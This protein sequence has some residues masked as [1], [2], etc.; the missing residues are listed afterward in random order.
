MARYSKTAVP[1]AA[2]WTTPS[3]PIERKRGELTLED[4]DLSGAS[5]AERARA[6]ELVRAFD[7]VKG[8]MR[9][10]WRETLAAFVHDGAWRRLATSPS[11]LESYKKLKGNA[12]RQKQLYYPFWFEGVDFS[13]DR[14]FYPKVGVKKEKT[15]FQGTIEKPAQPTLED[16]NPTRQFTSINT[17]PKAIIPRPPGA[18]RPAKTMIATLPQTDDAV[19][20]Q[21]CLPSGVDLEDEANAVTDSEHNSIFGPPSLQE[22]FARIAASRNVSAIY[23]NVEHLSPLKRAVSFNLPDGSRQSSPGRDHTLTPRPPSPVQPAGRTQLQSSPITVEDDLVPAL[24]RQRLDA[25]T[26]RQME[27]VKLRLN[28]IEAQRDIDLENFQRRLGTT[29]TTTGRFQDCFN[30]LSKNA[31]GVAERLAKTEQ[32]IDEDDR[33]LDV[34]ELQH[35]QFEERLTQVDERHTQI[36]MMA[37]LAQEAYEK[38]MEA[39]GLIQRIVDFLEWWGMVAQFITD[40]SHQAT[41]GVATPLRQMGMI[42]PLAGSVIVVHIS[43]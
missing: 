22:R 30:N 10:E 31:D 29:E 27:N 42:T 2:P 20:S 18:K 5:E 28:Y 21:L 40:R 17:A 15:C 35:P 8:N 12:G 43:V 16:P 23:K 39:L 24:K 19:T 14:I 4:W 25:T 13:A 38:A 6:E 1:G 33:R 36:E 26:S 41:S 7:F 9:D 11:T 37:Q 3:K 34:V 32:D